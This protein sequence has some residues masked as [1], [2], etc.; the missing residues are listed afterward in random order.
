MT[1]RA[2]CGLL[3]PL[4]LAL[5]GCVH[6]SGRS[7]AVPACPG[8]L[9]PSADLGGELLLRQRVE[10]EAGERRFVLR[11]I[12]QVSH[13]ELLLIGID[14]LGVKLFTL[15]Q[16]GS[17]V[18]VDALPA[19]VL[20]VEPITLLREVHRMRFLSA[21]AH[22]A[23]D[24]LVFVRQGT[25]IS[26]R[27]EGGTLRA[28]RLRRLDGDPQGVVTLLFETPGPGEEGLE[29][30]SIDNGWCGYRVEIVTLVEEQSR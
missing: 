6:L 15:R 12:T 28:R 17:E 18:E 8:Q 4:L 2:V 27:W 30:V 9:V 1:R 21:R 3:L 20:E 16:R 26:E 11:M 23:E 29:R 14:P 7:R 24:P 25:E 22:G 13:G 19:P 5:A 10:L